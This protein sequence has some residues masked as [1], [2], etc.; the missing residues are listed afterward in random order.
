MGNV[1]CRHIDVVDGQLYGQVRGAGGRRER[2]EEGDDR[3]CF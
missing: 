1:L 3:A 2:E